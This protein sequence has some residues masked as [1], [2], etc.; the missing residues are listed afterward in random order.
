V[1]IEIRLKPFLHRSDLRIICGTKKIYEK[2]VIAYLCGWFP[3]VGFTSELN[4][5]ASGCPQIVALCSR[6]NN[7][8]RIWRHENTERC[9]SRPYASNTF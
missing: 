2:T 8:R 9:T 7:N 3:G 5:H 4:G 1:G 6:L